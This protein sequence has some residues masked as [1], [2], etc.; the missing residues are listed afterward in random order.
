MIPR[1]FLLCSFLCWTLVST[2]WPSLGAHCSFFRYWLPKQ[3][4]SYWKSSSFSGRSHVRYG[5]Q[6]CF[7]P[8]PLFPSREHIPEEKGGK[9]ATA[10][11]NFNGACFIPWWGS[12]HGGGL[13]LSLVHHFYTA[14]FCTY[15][16]S[17][18]L[19]ISRYLF[20]L[21]VTPRQFLIIHEY[22]SFLVHTRVLRYG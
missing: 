20:F 17:V 21:Y 16:L 8:N 5:R 13:T 12:P 11:R 10:K 22:T 19:R 4:D 15:T 1:L 3:L 7:S 2:H 18:A 6:I 14:T 9:R